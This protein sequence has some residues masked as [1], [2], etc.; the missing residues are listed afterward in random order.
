[1]GTFTWSA[2]TSADWNTPADWTLVGE[3]GSPPPGSATTK[4]D[5]ATFGNSSSGTGGYAVTLFKGETFDIATI[6]IGNSGSFK[7][8]SLTITGT[9]LTNTLHYTTPAGKATTPITIG[10]GG[11]FDIRTDITTTSSVGQVLSIAA[12]VRDGAIGSGG[13]LELGSATNNGAGI[14]DAA[15]SAKF[16]N[17][18]ATVLNNGVIE[19]LGGFTTGETTNLTISSVANGDEFIFDGA[20]FNGDTATLSG[21]T[22]TVKSGSTTILTMNNVS[23]QASSLATFSVHGDAIVAVCYARGSMLQTPGGEVPVERMRAGKHI[24]T[25]VDG[26]ETV[27][28]VRWLGHRRIDL[29]THPRPETVAPV[30]IIRGAIADNVPHRDLVVS[31]DHAIFIDGK[32]ICARQLINSTTIRQETDWT[33]V[34]YY[35]VELDDHAILLAEGL[36]AESYLNTGNAGFF[37]NSGRPMVLHPDLTDESDYPNR[38]AGSCAP[39]V[40]DEGSVRP[41]WQRLAERAAAIGWPTPVYTTTVEPDLHLLARG[42]AI[43]PIYSDK[44]LVIFALPRGATQVQLASRAQSP[45]MACPWLEDRRRLGVRV[46]RIVLRGA[47][48]LREVPV[49]HPD[50]AKGWWA[51]ERDGIG[52]RRWTNGEAVLPLPDMDGDVML[53]I[54]LGGEMTY[55]VDHDLR[56]A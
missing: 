50:L 38:E 54:H 14:N 40:W 26:L 17:T 23:R 29:R 1:M 52:L 47:D 33:A 6:N 21:T 32:L 8:P 43:K 37:S 22:L 25:L 13:H 49:D 30:R 56:A 18:G 44:A 11:I 3:T 12:N 36:P 53:E 7:A 4:T 45:T 20:N 5:I 35:H 15:V 2:G 39:F 42:R 16:T 19:F 28:T 9:L 41:V 46:A 27:K 31:P 48:D 10:A 24:I 55:L 34:D 51:V